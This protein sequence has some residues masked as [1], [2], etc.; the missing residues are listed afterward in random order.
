LAAVTMPV[1]S[2][3]FG[4]PKLALLLLSVACLVIILKHRQNISRLLSGTENKFG[5]TKA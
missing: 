2:F 4:M 3:F 5:E 1:A